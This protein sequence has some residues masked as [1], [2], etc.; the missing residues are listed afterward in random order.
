MKKILLTITTIAFATFSFSQVISRD[1]VSSGGNYSS[2]SGYTLSSTIG[3][4]MIT[5]LATGSNVLTQGFQQSFSV[6]VINGCTD[7]TAT[8][9]DPNANVDDGSCSYG[10]TTP[11]SGL[12]MSDLIQD[13]ATFNFDNMNTSGCIVDQLRIKYR[14]VGTSS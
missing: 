7:S 11:I 4:T 13:R 12:F 5:T 8:N 1:V 14:V 10:C 2:N 6:N 3:E 9:Y